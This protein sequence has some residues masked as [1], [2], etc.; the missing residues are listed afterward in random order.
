[1][2]DIL[3]FEQI[4]NSRGYCKI[5]FKNFFFTIDK[6]LHFYVK[7]IDESIPNIDFFND[8]PIEKKVIGKKLKKKSRDFERNIL[9]SNIPWNHVFRF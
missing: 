9:L 2:H 8:Q 5:L 1:M 6:I 4:W 7:F 3:Q